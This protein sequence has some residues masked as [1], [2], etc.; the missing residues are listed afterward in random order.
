MQKLI[1][2]HFQIKGLKILQQG[3][4]ALTV[5]N[6]VLPDSVW[7]KCYLVSPSPSLTTYS[8]LFFTYFSPKHPFSLALSNIQLF[9]CPALT[10]PLLCIRV[11]PRA[12]R[13]QVCQVSDSRPG[14]PQKA[15]LFQANMPPMVEAKMMARI[16]QQIMIM[17]FFCSSQGERN[18]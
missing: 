16:I 17:I 13:V 8:E 14:P 10:H 3:W 5:R 2:L 4:T 7:G 12:P 6:T 11:T 18:T 1:L 15:H 9:L